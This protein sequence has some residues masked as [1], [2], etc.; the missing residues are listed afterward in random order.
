MAG[1]CF[2]NLIGKF[3]FITILCD[4]TMLYRKYFVSF[5]E[6]IHLG[7]EMDLNDCEMMSHVFHKLIFKNE[8]S[9]A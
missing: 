2:F 8:T 3:K 9:S 6:F 5:L 4:S 1:K 7:L